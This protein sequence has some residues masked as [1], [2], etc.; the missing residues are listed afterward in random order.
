MEP[1]V[2]KQPMAVSRKRI[3]HVF[4][5]QLTQRLTRLNPCLRLGS[6]DAQSP[7]GSLRSPVG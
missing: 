5:A 7:G 1:I 3:G 2:P 4:P 6:P